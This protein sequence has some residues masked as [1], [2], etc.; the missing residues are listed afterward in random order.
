MFTLLSGLTFDLLI[1]SLLFPPMGGLFFRL[2]LD[3]LLLLFSFSL[4]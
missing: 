2:A 3:A 1:L 4:A